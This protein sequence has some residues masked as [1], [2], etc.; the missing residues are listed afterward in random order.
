MTMAARRTSREG[1]CGGGGGVR[2]YNRSKVPR[3][4]WTS[5][6]HRCFVHAIHSL[7][8]HD[9][10]TPKRVLQVMGVGGLTISHVKS[11]LQMYRNMRNDLGMQGMQQAGQQSG[12]EEHT[13]A[14]GGGTEV[15]TDDDEECRVPGYGSPKPRKEST[16]LP[17]HPQLKR[18]AGASETVTREEVSASP[19]SLLRVKRGRGICEGRDGGGS[20]DVRHVAVLPLTCGPVGN[21]AHMSAAQWHTAHGRGAAS[22][23]DMESSSH[24]PAAAGGQYHVHMDMMQAHAVLQ[25]PPMA[26][27]R[28]VEPRP[29]MPLGMKQKQKHRREPWMPT[30]RLHR[31]GDGELGAAASTLK[32]LGFLVAPGRHPPRPRAACCDGYPIEVGT[33]PNRAA[34]YTASRTDGVRPCRLQPPGNVVDAGFTN[35]TLAGERDGGY[36]LSL[37]LALCPAGGGGAKSSLLSSSTASSSSSSSGS[38]ISLDLSL[39]TLDS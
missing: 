9:R 13:R 30:A 15:C 8:G 38:R 22:G 37:A 28:L 11:H 12:Q 19:T 31:G 10:A 14:T 4:R 35:L 26:A 16:T 29:S 3:L 39:S 23:R 6:L 7:G 1:N 21:L 24:A 5:A 27:A 17:L 32:F 2:Q 25:A 34:A 20:Y 18:R 33:P 36:S